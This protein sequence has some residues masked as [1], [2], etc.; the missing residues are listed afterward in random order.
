[1]IRYIC[2]ALVFLFGSA[3]PSAF[4]AQ[5]EEHPMVA[6]TD[7]GT[8]QGAATCDINLRNAEQA[9]C[10]YVIERLVEDGHFAV[11]DRA[12]VE[13]RLQAD[14]ITAVGLIDPD[15][16][17]QIG[18][19]LGA[20]YLIYGNVNDVSVSATGTEL[21]GNGV[22]VGTVKAHIIARMMDVQTGDIVMAAKGEGKSKT[23]YVKVKTQPVGIITI[24]TKKVTQDSV[25]NALQ[26]AAYAAVDLLASRLYGNEEGAKKK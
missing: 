24:G 2:L 3:A 14:D 22:T 1:M 7:F 19:I 18:E 8:H 26:K 10:E 23:S 6:V 11:M 16:A 20:R 13:Q 9:S 5:A 21:A 25:H 12:L 17:R 15:T 4:A